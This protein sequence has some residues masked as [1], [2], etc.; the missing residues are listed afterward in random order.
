MF[1]PKERRGVELGFS[2]MKSGKMGVFSRF[3][4][5]IHLVFLAF[6]FFFFVFDPATIV[7]SNTQFRAFSIKNF[8]FVWHISIFFEIWSMHG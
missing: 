8:R 7:T 2:G 5:A 6:P 3:W 4:S 1:F